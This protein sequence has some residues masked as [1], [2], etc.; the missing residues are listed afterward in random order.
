V[1]TRPSCQ[2]A[3]IDSTDGVEVHE[4]F[5]QPGSAQQI[6]MRLDL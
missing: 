5:T 4:T 2:T 1:P 3:V 6:A